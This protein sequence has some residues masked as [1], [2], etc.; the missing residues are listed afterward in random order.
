MTTLNTLID[1][2]NLSK[3]STVVVGIVNTP[4][5]WSQPFATNGAECLLLGTRAWHELSSNEGMF[6]LLDRALAQQPDTPAGILFGVPV[7]VDA[8]ALNDPTHETLVPAHS[9]TAFYKDGSCCFYTLLTGVVASEFQVEDKDGF[10]YVYEDGRLV[11]FTSKEL[12]ELDRR[13]PNST[14]PP[15]GYYPPIKDG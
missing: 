5:G 6:S 10:R 2:F 8:A 1:R 4:Q 15:F 12:I 3:H 13:L 9:I 7:Y 11:A 14:V